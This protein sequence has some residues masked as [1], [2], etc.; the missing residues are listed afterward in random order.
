M[1]LR[2]NQYWYIGNQPP[3]G[4]VKTSLTDQLSTLGGLWLS[5]FEIKGCEPSPTNHVTRYKSLF[6][7]QSFNPQDSPYNSLDT[8]KQNELWRL[9]MI[10][11]VSCSHT[12]GDPGDNVTWTLCRPGGAGGQY[13]WGHL[14]LD[15]VRLA[16]RSVTSI[17]QLLERIS[18]TWIKSKLN[19]IQRWRFACIETLKVLSRLFSYQKLKLKKIGK[20]T[21]IKICS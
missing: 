9:M 16:A 1:W 7:W 5:I 2:F 18:E 6:D 3:A 4:R 15:P 10:S 21:S 19:E 14:F 12:A 17:K 13:S 8:R 11:C 20:I